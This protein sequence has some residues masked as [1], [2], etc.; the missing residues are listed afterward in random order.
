M[1]YYTG[2][3]SKETPDDILDLMKRLAFWL[4][5]GGFTLRSG[6]AR[7]ADT[8]FELGARRS[9]KIYYANDGDCPIASRIAGQFHPKWE[10]LGENTKRLHT[11]NVFQV[12]GRDLCAPSE[13][14]LCWTP[15]GA[16][17]HAERTRLDGGTGTAISVAS[18]YGIP[19]HN[20]K[21]PTTLEYCANWVEACTLQ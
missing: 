9:K 3:G 20:L 15:G 4:Y 5:M 2:I 13:F 11:R 8:A 1:K 18:H 16:T 21:N 19:V 7:G 10:K 6:G 12:L 14:I 17:N